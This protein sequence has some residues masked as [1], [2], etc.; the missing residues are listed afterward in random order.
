MEL[1][2]ENGSSIDTGNVTTKIWMT[3][4]MKLPE[5]TTEPS[6]KST[7]PLMIII[8]PID[9]KSGNWGD[10]SEETELSVKDYN[11]H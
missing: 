4:T 7:K 10:E 3:A 1:L 6:K 5:A 11:A 9:A 8:R 2:V